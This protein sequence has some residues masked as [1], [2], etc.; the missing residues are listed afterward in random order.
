MW[1]LWGVQRGERERG[2][3]NN[4]SQNAPKYTKHTKCSILPNYSVK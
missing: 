2:I 3:M 4:Y 1:G